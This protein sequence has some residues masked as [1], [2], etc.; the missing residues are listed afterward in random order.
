[1][2]PFF[3]IRLVILPL[4]ALGMVSGRLAASLGV[5]LTMWLVWVETL[6]LLLS[7]Q[8]QLL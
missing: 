3:G 7:N 2:A 1:L 5:R 6:A 4:V 8:I